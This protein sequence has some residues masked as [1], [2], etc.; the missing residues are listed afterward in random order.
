MGGAGIADRVRQVVDDLVG[1][2]SQPRPVALNSTAVHTGQCQVL[3]VVCADTGIGQ[4]SS[5]CLL[6]QRRVGD[7]AEALLPYPRTRRARYP[8]TFQEFIGGHAR[9]EI[10]SDHRACRPV[11]HQQRRGAVA[12][13]RLVARGGHAVANV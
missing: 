2:D 10:L 8:P 5:K 3:H 9:T 12:A 1:G 6:N 7:L 13:C 4:S 11:A